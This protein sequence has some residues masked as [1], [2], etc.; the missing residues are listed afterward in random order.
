[1]NYPF[2]RSH[3]YFDELAW[4]AMWM[5]KATDEGAYLTKALS[6]WDNNSGKAWAFDWDDKETGY[7][8]S[9]IL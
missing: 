9:Y 6:F 8:A 5:Y 1:M 2:Y 7:Q 4:G 3:G